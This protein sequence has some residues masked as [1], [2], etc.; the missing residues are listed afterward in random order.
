MSSKARGIGEDALAGKP[1][2]MAMPPVLVKLIAD[3][4]RV[5]TY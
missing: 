5:V 1:A 4:D 2:E 3:S